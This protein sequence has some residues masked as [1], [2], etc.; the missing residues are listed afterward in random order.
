MSPVA[1]RLAA[2]TLVLAGAFGTAYAAGEKLPGHTHNG[3]DAHSHSNTVGPIPA[4]SD[5]DGYRLITDTG[6]GSNELAFHVTDPSGRRVTDL[7]EV[8]GALLHTVLVRPDLSG[9]QHVHP[10]IAADGSWVVPIEQ[11][12][13][14]HIVF[15]LL[16]AGAAREIVLTID[17]DDGTAVPTTPLPAADDTVESDG[18]TVTRNGLSF[19]VSPSDGLEPYLGQAAHL[20]A[21]RQG[22]LAYEHLHPTDAMTGMLM[23]GDA[24]GAPGTYRLFLQFGY[25]GEVL[26]VPFTVVQS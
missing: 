6:A 19:T 20:V 18:L 24:L 9:F 10:D 21:I 3:S 5:S 8:H 2:F 25:R 4:A 16:P 12:G 7:T 22:D 17:T 1:A 23:F 11:P 26:T 14:W 15:E 13:P